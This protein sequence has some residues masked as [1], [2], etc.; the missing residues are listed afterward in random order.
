MTAGEI[1]CPAVVVVGCCT[2]TTLF[3]A[4]A[5][6][7]KESLAAV[8]ALLVAVRTLGPMRLMLRF[9]KVARPLAFVVCVN[10]PLSVPVPEDFDITTDAPDTLLPNWSCA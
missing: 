4:A 1:A 2:N 8:F 6:M 5:V 9:A 7:L 10:V 3:A